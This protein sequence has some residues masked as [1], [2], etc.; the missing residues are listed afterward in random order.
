MG[1]EG[2]SGG[3]R[4]HLRKFQRWH[5]RWFRRRYRGGFGG[6]GGSHVRYIGSKGV[7]VIFGGISGSFSASFRRFSGVYQEV[8][9]GFSEV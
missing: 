5:F 3:F 2:Y 8:F 4:W 6:F 1:S 7:Q 9:K